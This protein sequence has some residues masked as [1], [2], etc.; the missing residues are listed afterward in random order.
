MKRIL[1]PAALPTK[2]E[3]DALRAIEKA[4]LP[5]EQWEEALWQAFLLKRNCLLLIQDQG[6][7]LFTL[8]DQEAELIKI[9]VSPKAQSKGLGTKLLETGMQE[10]E[11]QGVSHF[12]LEVRKSNEAAQKLYLRQGFKQTGE[13]KDYYKQPRED[14]LI[15]SK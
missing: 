8:L 10:A 7:A 15:Y 3:L 11:K 1:S 4:A 9:A 14:A 5:G 6:F 13:R 2:E 12:F